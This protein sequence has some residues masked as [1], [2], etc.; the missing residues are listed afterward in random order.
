MGDSPS[1]ESVM[2]ARQLLPP[3]LIFHAT[4][5]SSLN[6]CLNETPLATDG[7]VV[8]ELHHAK[9]SL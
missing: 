4:V 1:F 8:H 5:S 6:G 2:Y 7:S 9:P 3:P